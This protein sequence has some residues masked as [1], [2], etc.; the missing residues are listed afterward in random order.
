MNVNKRLRRI[1]SNAGPEIQSK[2]IALFYVVVFLAIAGIVLTARSFL[3][4]FSV[5][6]FG[7][8]ILVIAN[9]VT[10][11][12][13]ISGRY[14][15]AVNITLAVSYLVISY[16]NLTTQSVGP[17]EYLTSTIG[18]FAPIIV[19][20]AVYGYARWQGA[21][22][23]AGAVIN[24]VLVYI[25]RSLPAFRE[26]LIDHP[27][28]NLIATFISPVLIGLFI[29]IIQTNY[30]TALRM[31]R[32][33]E[34]RSRTGYE[35]AAGV[36]ESVRRGLSA[37][38]ELNA[39]AEKTVT[40][41][42]SIKKELESMRNE[43]AR[44]CGQVVEVQE[45][46]RKMLDR[47]DII[48]AR[49]DDQ[50]AAVN[51][52]SS[53]INQMASSIRSISVS[54]RERQALLESLRQSAKDGAEQLDESL[55]AFDGIKKSSE[56]MMEI[57]SVIEG[58]AGRTNLLAMNAAIEA[59][60]AGEAGKGFSIVADEI[61]TL[62]EETN[63]NSRAIRNL[64]EENARLIGTTSETG[65]VNIRQIFGLVEKLG[66]ISSA[67][68]EILY[69]MEELG[70]GAGEILSTVGVLKD[71]NDEANVSL[72]EIGSLISGGSD[73]VETIHEVAGV[74]EVRIATIIDSSD[75]IVNEAKTV[76]SIGRRNEQNIRGLEEA[77]DD[78]KTAMD[79]EDKVDT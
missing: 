5:A 62:S 43:I 35:K 51:E 15:V 69:G 53:S 70:S 8:F 19:S 48:R 66:G 56:E 71:S 78:I 41:T 74:V 22:M 26:G 11:A 24:L 25:F 10:I 50:S 54:A 60:H 3:T 4:R 65:S 32:S 75:A 38:K 29:F 16:V 45:Y 55:S 20:V 77:V 63:E 31:S 14:K 7:G 49:M 34:L 39:S 72:N 58:I 9:I 64:L 40:L 12:L 68:E 57:I 67:M 46:Q 18:Y 79:E 28:S 13:L 73:T 76:F 27:F 33:A 36:I 61:R 30:Q 23:S 42:E 17:S 44:L 59:A 52:S 6:A 47:R 1:Y 21:A 37:G 2:S